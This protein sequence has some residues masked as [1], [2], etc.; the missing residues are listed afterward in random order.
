MVKSTVIVLC[1]IETGLSFTGIS[2]RNNIGVSFE[3]RKSTYAFL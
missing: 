1:R 3:K 2:K